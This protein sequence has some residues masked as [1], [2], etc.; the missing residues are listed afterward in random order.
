MEQDNIR[1]YFK[2][3]LE[4]NKEASPEAIDILKKL[5]DHTIAFRDELKEK[6]DVPLTVEDTKQAIDIYLEAVRTERLRSDLDPKIDS[7]VKYWLIKV[8]GATF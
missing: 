7:L 6:A 8:N 1:E 2:T 3:I 5:I 4:K